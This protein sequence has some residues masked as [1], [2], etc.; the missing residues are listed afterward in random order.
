VLRRLLSDEEAQDLIE[1][2]LLGATCAIAGLAAYNRLDDIIRIVYTNWD[3]ATQAL[4]EPQNP[5]P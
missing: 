5:Q 3:T 4:W 1:Y 2:V